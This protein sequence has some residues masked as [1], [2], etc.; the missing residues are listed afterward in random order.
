MQTSSAKT[1]FCRIVV[2][3]L[4]HNRTKQHHCGHHKNNKQKNKITIKTNYKKHNDHKSS[5]QKQITKNKSQTKKKTSGGV[6]RTQKGQLQNPLLGSESS[7]KPWTSLPQPWISPSRKR[8]NPPPGSAT[9]PL[10]G[11]NPPPESGTEH[12]KPLEGPFRAHADARKDLAARNPQHNTTNG[13]R[14]S[15]HHRMIFTC[16]WHNKE[17]ARWL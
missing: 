3:A 4:S 9:A 8:F 6:R 1:S 7:P 11:F 12:N 17:R 2:T 13:N 15:E 14:Y 10:R 16:Q 5:Q